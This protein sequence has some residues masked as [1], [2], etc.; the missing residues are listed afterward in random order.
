MKKLDGIC[1][2]VAATFDDYGE[3]DPESFRNLVQHL[4]KTGVRG[5]TL[6]GLVTEFYKLT[7]AEKQTLMQIMLAETRQSPVVAGVVSIT[8]HAWE[9]A[10]R[11]AKEAEIA[12]ADG[13]MVLPPFFLGASEAAMMSHLRAIATA[14]SIPIVVQY[15][16]VQTGVKISPEVFFQLREEYENIQYV[17][18]E[19]QPPG[20][21][22]SALQEGSAGKIESLVGYAGVQMPDVLS[23]GAV[24]IQPG[25]S[26]SEVY[27]RLFELFSTGNLPGMLN[28][29]RRLLPFI[30]YW[31]QS[32]E[33]LIKAE[34]SILKR[35]GI[36]KTDYCRGISYVM[37]ERESRMIDDF[38]LEFAEFLVGHESV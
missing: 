19:C 32:I 2:I 36:I 7:D 9:V 12:G 26:F 8:D 31:M 1:P 18:V 3:L 22:V 16:P 20:L 13:L 5:L 23:R 35:R 4:I 30:S 15:A 25:C 28:L 27:V 38:L 14:V 21:Y 29:H 6:F 33:L 37:D 34:K 17:K 10:V 11:R 24:G